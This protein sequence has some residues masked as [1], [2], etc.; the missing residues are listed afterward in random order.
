MKELFDLVSSLSSTEKQQFKKRHRSDSDY[1]YLFDFI[2]KLQKY[3]NEKALAYLNKKR[4][5][6]NDI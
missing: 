5:V 1:I 4:K 2:N 6:K 3:D